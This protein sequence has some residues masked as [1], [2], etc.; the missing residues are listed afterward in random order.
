MSAR[1]WRPYISPASVQTQPWVLDL[2][3]E[4][5]GSGISHCLIKPGRG[6]AAA[7]PET[8]QTFR[9]LYDPAV[10]TGS[11][12]TD[13]DSSST[14]STRSLDGSRPSYRNRLR[15]DRKEIQLHRHSLMNIG[16]FVQTGT[17]GTVVGTTGPQAAAVQFRTVQRKSPS[18]INSIVP[19][20]A[21]IFMRRIVC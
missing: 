10:L 13:Q 9:C 14:S 1:P 15:L 4:Q 11:S 19:K 5:P 2:V 20:Q 12:L 16:Q 17:T 8:P 21:D 6:A 7:P 18:S 3:Q